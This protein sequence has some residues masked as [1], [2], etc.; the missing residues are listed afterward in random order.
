VDEESA[1]RQC[2]RG[3]RAAFAVLVGIHQSAVLSLCLRMTGNRPD[4][5]DV[6][7]QAFLKAFQHIDQFDPNLSFRPWLL[8]IAANESI[9]LIRRRGKQAIPVSDEALEQ[10]YDP[11]G[12]FERLTDDRQSIQAAVQSLPQQYR[13]IILLHYFQELGYQEIADLTGIAVGTVGTHLY[14]A[15]RRLKQILTQD[16]RDRG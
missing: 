4:A 9:A 10:V 8:R 7:Q 3:D 15:K 1:I 13:S 14:R 11:L 12:G 16:G 6:S 5:L 2:R